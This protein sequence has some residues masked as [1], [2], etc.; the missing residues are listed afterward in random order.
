MTLTFFFIN[1]EIFTSNLL[2]MLS[3]TRSAA[4]AV[5]KNIVATTAAALQ[6][7][8]STTMEQ[9]EDSNDADNDEPMKKKFKDNTETE[10]IHRLMRHGNIFDF[11][12]F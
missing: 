11:G 5:L 9:K 1:E 7:T 8:A 6:E 10:V 4:Q 3:P 2:D 12:T